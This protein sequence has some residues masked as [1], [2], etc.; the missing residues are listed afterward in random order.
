MPAVRMDYPGS[1][2]LAHSYWFIGEVT[3]RLKVPVLKTGEG[4]PS[5][6]SN[7]TLSATNKRGPLGPFS[8][9]RDGWI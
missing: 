7:P 8:F 4:R 1:P 9:V 3:E 6:G 5:V 2:Q